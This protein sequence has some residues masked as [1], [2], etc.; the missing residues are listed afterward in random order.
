M[1]GHGIFMLFFPVALDFAPPGPHKHG[2]ARNA[3]LRRALTPPLYFTS[4]LSF[5]LAKI[6]PLFPFIQMVFDALIS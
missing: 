6:L 5:L 3:L 2:C 4:V 1:R